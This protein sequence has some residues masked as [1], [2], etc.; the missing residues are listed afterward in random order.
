MFFCSVANSQDTLQGTYKDYR[1]KAGEYLINENVRFNGS[2]VISPNVKI[3]FEKKGT[4]VIGG[5]VRAISENFDIEFIG[6]EG[7]AGNG[8]IIIDKQNVEIEFK[9]AVFKNLNSPLFFENRWYRTKVN[10]QNSIFIQN[11]GKIGL[12]QILTPYNS[13]FDNDLPIEFNLNSNLFAE[14][15]SSIFIQDLGSLNSKIEITNNTFINNKIFGLESYTI[16]SNLIYGRLDEINAVNV[17]K[18][19]ANSFID[20]YLVNNLTGLKI[21]KANLGIYGTKET[22]NIGGN[23]FG[24]IDPDQIANSIYDKKYNYNSPLVAFEPF[25]TAPNPKNPSHIYGVLNFE[26]KE[27]KSNILLNEPLE[28]FITLSNTF[29]DLT[30]AEL[31]YVYLKDTLSTEAS[32]KVIPFKFKPGEQGINVAVS[33]EFN[34]LK[35][36][37]GYLELDN[38]IDANKTY[39]PKLQIGQLAF[40]EEKIK[41]KAT[42]DKIEKEMELLKKQQDSIKANEEEISKIELGKF[43]V[44]LIAGGAI[45]RGS[46]SNNNFMENDLNISFGIDIGY[47]VNPYLTARIN[48][49][50]STLSNSDINSGDADKINRGMNF[51]TPILSISPGIDFDLI[52]NR[53]NPKVNKVRPSIGIGLDAISFKPTG[54]FNGQEYDLASLGTGGQFLNE[55]T[56]PYATFTLGLYVTFKL[57]YQIGKNSIGLFA[58]YHSTLTDYLDDVGADPYPDRDALYNSNGENGGASVYFSNPTSINTTNRLRS[59]P[60]SGNDSFVKVG[61]SI[62]RKLFNPKN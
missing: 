37:V 57:K 51:S 17:T 18:I 2:L 52:N 11:Y 39:V 10:I 44:G 9:G 45:F 16:S 24:T 19:E 61:I 48:I 42:L 55:E 5:S 20:N 54:I 32:K 25:L 14:N 4:M 47:N 38:I 27:I 40:G 58:S 7:N 21:K 36:K 50:S 49:S 34:E 15:N 6:A 22:F 43:E 29:I 31:S 12:I 30:N 59:D 23:F 33:K 1:I 8:L 62:T 56:E 26:G 46:I 41:I 3:I 28:E 35:G 53:S 60:S 13:Y